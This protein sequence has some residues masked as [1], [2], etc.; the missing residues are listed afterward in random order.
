MLA[1]VTK[2]KNYGE[3]FKEMAAKDS[4]T[5]G[6][7]SIFDVSGKKKAWKKARLRALKKKNGKRCYG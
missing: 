4:A 7:I 3:A 5:K 2:N 1:A 6:E